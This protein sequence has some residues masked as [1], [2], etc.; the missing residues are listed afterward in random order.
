MLLRFANTF[1]C[2]QPTLKD[3]FPWHSILV[4]DDCFCLS[5]GAVKY[6]AGSDG[7]EGGCMVKSIQWVGVRVIQGQ[8]I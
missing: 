8:D 5:S 7:W 4:Y 6:E 1:H 3:R 2:S